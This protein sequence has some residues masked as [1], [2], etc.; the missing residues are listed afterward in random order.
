MLS[1]IAAVAFLTDVDRFPRKS[2]S[3]FCVMRATHKF[4]SL[5][6]VCSP[7]F[8]LSPPRVAFSRAGDF[9]A[10]S[11]FARSTIPEDKWGS[12][13][14]LTLKVMYPQ[15]L[16]GFSEDQIWQVIA[17]AFKM[18]TLDDVWCYVEIWNLNHAFT[19]LDILK[20]SVWRHLWNR[21]AFF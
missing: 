10:R 15:F 17:N 18:F 12:T 21:L 2:Q 5:G 11:L 4:K 1:A 20:S 19:I 9:H 14:S 6:F 16:F 7:S 8:S 3:K 13:R